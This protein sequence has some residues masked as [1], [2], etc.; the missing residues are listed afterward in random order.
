MLNI[1]NKTEETLVDVSAENFWSTV[2]TKN[3]IEP[4]IAY[5]KFPALNCVP[6]ILEMDYSR[7][8]NKPFFV[9]NITWN[10]TDVANIVISSL[11]FPLDFLNNPLVQV[12]FNASVYYRAKAHLMLQVSGTPM[13]AGTLIVSALPTDAGTNTTSPRMRINTYM[14]APHVFL[15]ANEATPALLEVPFYVNSKLASI[16][17]DGNTPTYTT[18][19]GNYADILFQVL[20]QLSAPTGASTSL[21]VSVHVIFKDLEFYVPHVNPSYIAPTAIRAFDDEFTEESNFMQTAKGFVTDIFDRATQGLKNGA[22]SVADGIAATISG[23]KPLLYDA[24]D[25]GRGYLRTLTGLHNPADTTISSKC[26]V[27]LRQYNNIVDAPIQ[28][29][30]L[31]PYSQFSHY[32]RDYTFDTARDE[33][34]MQSILKKPQFL[35][36]FI[37]K[38]TDSAGKLLWS[39][40]ITP[41]QDVGVVSI[42]VATGT[43]STN[44]FAFSNN[45]QTLYTLTRYWKGTIKIHIQAAMSNFQFCKLTLARNYSPDIRALSQVPSFDSIPNLMMESAEFSA[46]GQVQTFELPFCA[47]L[48]QIPNT[49]DIVAN[50]L[51][52]GMYYIYLHQPLVNNGT[53]T[54]DA[55]FNV[56]ISVGDDFQ[57]YGYN[58]RPLLGAW[59]KINQ[60]VGRDNLN[61][62]SV[63]TLERAVDPDAA[64]DPADEESFSAESAEVDATQSDIVF[65]VEK[66]SDVTES[67]LRP[68]VSVRDFT[69]RFTRVYYERFVPA[70]LANRR[71][72]AVFDVASLLAARSPPYLAPVAGG[73][74]SEGTNTIRAVSEM[75]MGYSGGSRFKV[76]VLG[77]NVAE[78]WYVPPGFLTKGYS[79]ADP[80]NNKDWRTTIPFASDQSDPV[81]SA[82]KTWSTLP[83]I[84]GERTPYPAN[85]TS[86]VMAQTVSQDKPNY[87]ASVGGVD[88]SFD[89]GSGTNRM[90]MAVTSFEFE[91]PHMTPF[92][93]VGDSSKSKVQQID[94]FV[95]NGACTGMG[96]IVLKMTSPVLYYPGVPTINADLAVEVF[97]ATDDVGRFG[98]QVMAPMLAFPV[99]VVDTPTLGV[100]DPVLLTNE[101][102]ATQAS[103]TTFTPYSPGRVVSQATPPVYNY[104]SLYFST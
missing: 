58:S 38:S 7:I 86:T 31:D 40:P 77:T 36:T 35:S 75:F 93:F 67:D 94:T 20:N 104:S 55:R 27:Q 51:S 14:S 66:T 65:K 22:S 44:T 99:G 78:A 17:L 10:T 71:N 83:F 74:V 16:S 72:I 101:A 26:A 12:P 56:Y 19:T 50:A 9:K 41:F 48:E 97:A 6:K 84:Y 63:L 57:Y 24:I 59:V 70:D 54:F 60:Q 103:T 39:R 96:H 1:L 49:V 85:Y 88:L 32:T 30:K 79:A 92:R 53:A 68:I 90:P 46:G 64:V 69:R 21:S 81:N 8:L 61:P 47:P 62:N 100:V 37:V 29:E 73:A 82:N 5:E 52:H 98:Y 33:M 2:R 3:A 80:A 95:S 18:F 87:L 42:P 43:I 91:I 34:D 76:N 28:L 23:A 11:N 4:E 13:H 25:M 102:A 45:I 15:S 89:T